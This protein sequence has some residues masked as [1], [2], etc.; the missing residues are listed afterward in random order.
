MHVDMVLKWIET[1]AII[2]SPICPHISEQ[3][4]Q[5]LGKVI[6]P[7]KLYQHVFIG[8][9]NTF[10]IFN[11]EK[12]TKLNSH[13]YLISRKALLCAQGGPLLHVLMI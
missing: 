13:I 10:S 6:I 5:I 4:W 1:Q 11:V 9:S 12:E 7:T 3:I 2:L 8:I